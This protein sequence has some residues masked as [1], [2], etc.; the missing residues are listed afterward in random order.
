VSVH[1]APAAAPDVSAGLCG[2]GGVLLYHP[3]GA[4]G[5]AFGWIADHQLALRGAVVGGTLG[6]LGDAGIY[7]LQSALNRFDAHKL[8]GVSGQGLPVI[9]QPQEERDI[10]RARAAGTVEESDGSYWS[11]RANPKR[12]G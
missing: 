5:S 9:S 10:G 3:D 11:S 2:A 12:D 8:I 4:L 7:D 1:L 6:S